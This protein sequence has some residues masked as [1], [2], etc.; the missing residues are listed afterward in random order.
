MVGFVGR[1]IL[2]AAPLLGIVLTIVFF[3]VEAA[4]G[5]PFSQE[6]GAGADRQAAGRLGHAFDADKPL[7]QRYLSWLGGFLSGH[8]GTSWSHRRPV[9]D[10]LRESVANTG[11][12]AGSAIVLQ[13]LLGTA[14]G[15]AV[16]GLRSRFWDRAASALASVLYSCPS[17]WLGLLLV[18]LFSVRMGWLPVSQM[19]SVDAGSMGPWGR[20]FDAWRHLVLPCLALTLPAAAGIGLYVREE[21]RAILARSPARNALARGATRREI[22]L[23]HALKGALLPVVTLLGLALPG[24]V[25]GSAV[26]EVLFAWPG[27]GRLAYQA[28]LARDE[29]LVLGCAWVGSMA[30]VA[31]SLV[32]D[33][34]ASWVDPRLRDVP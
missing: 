19:H 25:G 18:S 2:A 23:K 8:L 32:A 13:F 17:Y 24:L 9:S 28:V 6:P 15:I 3:L 4:P 10:L 1:R 20:V 33:L 11:V 22:L 12:L 27:M 16:A 31:G 21:M 7:P 29:P 14:G 34:L 5:D 30:V 26:L